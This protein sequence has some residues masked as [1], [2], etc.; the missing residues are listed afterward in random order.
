MRLTLFLTAALLPVF[1]T[2]QAPL[3]WDKFSSVSAAKGVT[4]EELAAN[5]TS[6]FTSE[7]DKAAAIYYWTTHNI[8]Y[9]TKMLEKMRKEGFKRERLPKAE[10]AKRKN[11]QIQYAFQKHKGVCQNYARLFRSLCIVVGLECDFISGYARGN[12]MK[13]GTLGVGHAW[14]VV[15]IDGEWTL[16]DAT[17]GA[18]NVNSKNKF[19]FKFKPGYFMPDPGSFSYSHLP[20][21]PQW[22]LVEEPLTE[23]QFL[24][25]PATSSGFL[26][27]GLKDL[28]HVTYRLNLEKGDPLKISFKASESPGEIICVNMTLSRQIPCTATAKGEEY[29]ITVP[30]R[31]VRNMVLNLRNAKNEGLVSYRLSVR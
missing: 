18:G 17:W 12:V 9:D 13:P 8:A 5:I 10:V 15:K 7:T 3:D 29:I 6:G 19:V 27:Y 1:L 25:Q 23:E 14:N 4:V 31:E 2:A 28:N 21:D 30:K 26:S 11:D 24:V 20:K 22:Q 16:I